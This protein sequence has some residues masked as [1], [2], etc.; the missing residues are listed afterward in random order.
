MPE[1]VTMPASDV[2]RA[3]KVYASLE[4]QQDDRSPIVDIRDEPDGRLRRV[5]CVTSLVAQ[6]CDPQARRRAQSATRPAN[7]SPG[8]EGGR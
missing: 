8:S 5:D 2:D 1:V 6:Q 4:R 3:K 7:G